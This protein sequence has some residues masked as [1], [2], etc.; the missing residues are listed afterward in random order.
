MSDITYKHTARV[1]ADSWFIRFYRWL[2]EADLDQ[3]DF[4]R[5]FWGY[6][7]AIPNLLVRVIG[8]LPYKLGL[9]I[10][11]KTEDRRKSWKLTPADEVAIR[12][13]A[14]ANRVERKQKFE[15]FFAKVGATADKIVAFGKAVWPIAKYPV[16]AAAS[17]AGAAVVCL[18][19]VGLYELALII[20]E[21][22][23]DVLHVL[24]IVLAGIA[25]IALL[26]GIVLGLAWFFVDTR[27]GKQVRTGTKGGFLT[28]T[29]AIRTGFFG[30]KSR[31][32]PKIEIVDEGVSA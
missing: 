14:R 15:R 23:T 31:T 16:Y 11:E 13:R 17:I 8:Y 20:I 6:V 29:G 19:G 10:A 12:A 27:Y 30:I 3:V 32:C 24:L 2:W 26:L 21:N 18:V 22:S 25:G 7:F 28:F 1:K 9:A 4:C 5:L